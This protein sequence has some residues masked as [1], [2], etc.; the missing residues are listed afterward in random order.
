MNP[1]VES[2]FRAPQKWR[3]EME[4]MRELILACGLTE[5]LK[6]GKPCYMFRERNIVII[7]EFKESCALLFCQ[8]ALLRDPRGILEKPGEHSHETRR[9]RF[10]EVREIVGLKPVLQAYIHEAIAA[11]KAGLKVDSKRKPEPIPDELQDR[12]D[13]IPAL[14][15]AFSALTP[16][17][18][19]AYVLY[20][21]AAKQSK[22]R[23]ARVEKCLG[24]ILKGQ[25]LHD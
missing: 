3:K 21:S 7:Q 10:T 5:T 16:G 17:R 2:Y 25:G 11:E 4:K 14:K 20:F 13:G 12:L 9:I 1:K 19:R 15:T 18:Q 24:L 23:A 6:W 8:G 22:T